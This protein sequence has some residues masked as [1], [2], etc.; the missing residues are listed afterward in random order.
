MPIRKFRDGS[1]ATVLREPP[2]RGENLRV[3]VEL[4]AFCLR[5]RPSSSPRGVYRFRSIAEA[6]ADA[7]SLEAGPG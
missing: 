4:S 5:L 3:A 7:N 1:E 2:L 6:K